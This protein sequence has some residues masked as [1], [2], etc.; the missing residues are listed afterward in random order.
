MF[1]NSVEQLLHRK[2]VLAA[3]IAAIAF[4]GFYFWGVS[5]AASALEE[6]SAGYPEMNLLTPADTALGALLTAGPFASML[7]TA[8][9]IVLGSS[10]LPEEISGGRISLWLSLPQSRFKTFL[11][12][13]LAPLALSI[14]LSFI[15]F[16]GITLITYTCFHF[17]PRAILLAIVSMIA[18][19]S[20]IWATV[21]TFSLIMGKI[22]SMLLAFFCAGV[23][24]MIGGIYEIGRMFPG[25]IP[26][27]LQNV[28]KTVMILFP[29]DRGYRGVLYGII[30]KD[31]IL[32]ENF[33]FFGV[34]ANIPFWQIIY[35]FAWTAFV[36]FIGFLL[37]K[38]RDF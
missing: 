4:L 1:V 14:V 8:L 25:E 33:A 19:L 24:S 6:Q 34:S 2:I 11:G 36:L 13:S 37:F 31:A 32:T 23:A 10:S 3:L 35:C 22:A 21:I 26:T 27:G 18:W 15:L 7:I 20:V 16:S 17:S 12:I 30:P 5:A 28:A 38:K 29:A 9:V